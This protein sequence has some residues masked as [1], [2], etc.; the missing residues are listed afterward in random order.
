[1]KRPG[2]KIYS[3]KVLIANPEQVTPTHFHYQKME[4][5]IN[6]GGGDLV[7]QFWNSTENEETA[8]TEVALSLDGVRT[9][10]GAGRT[11]TLKPGESVCIKQKQYHK[12]WGAPGRGT[13]LVGEVSRINDDYLDNHFLEPIGRFPEIDE[14]EPPLFLLYDDYKRY[15]RHAL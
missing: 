5:I 15:Y 1:M 8:D 7:I 6:R 14:D 2:G 12:F 11:V 3:G 4:D 10:V 13:V 9:T